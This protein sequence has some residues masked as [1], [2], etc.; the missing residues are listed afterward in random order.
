M[1]Q[2]GWCPGGT[3][4]PRRTRC[5]RSCSSAVHADRPSARRVAA[6]AVVACRSSSRS[7]DRCAIDVPRC[8]PRFRR[9]RLEDFSEARRASVTAW[10]SGIF[11]GVLPSVVLLVVSPRNFVFGNLGWASVRSDW[12]LSET[13]RRR[14]TSCM[15]FSAK[16]LST[17]RYSRWRSSRSFC[18]SSG[19]TTATCE[20]NT[21]AM[22]VASVLP[23]PTYTQYF[24]A[25][26]PFLI[27]TAL[28]L[29]PMWARCSRNRNMP[30]LVAPAIVLV[31]AGSAIFLVEG[32]R[33]IRYAQ[34]AGRR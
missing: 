14:S 6:S 29:F 30:F 23:T 7:C 20:L 13:C 8:A 10:A 21:A 33:G 16:N 9:V 1:R 5:Q 11:L 4:Q 31:V 28:E 22:A 18:C 32:A 2:R 24:C 17:W 15:T 25:T 26:V 19:A 27:F 12:V 34:Q 3:Q